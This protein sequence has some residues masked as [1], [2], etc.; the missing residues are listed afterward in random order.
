MSKKG[1]YKDNIILVGLIF[2]IFVILG[3]FLNKF[4]FTYISNLSFQIEDILNYYN[5]DI[6]V[7]DAVAANLKE[8]IRYL[9][10]IAVLTLS[11]IGF[12]AALIVFLIRALSIGYTINTCI[13]VLKLK[14]IKIC[15]LVFMK[16]LII[17]PTAFILFTLSI[18][19]IKNIYK[20]LKKGKQESILFLGKKYLYKAS[21]VIILGIVLQLFL[22]IIII[23]ILKFLL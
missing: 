5:A 20:Q 9:V 17:I 12:I 16:N 18:Q 10:L 15:F 23:S 19:Y 2:L 8:D 1:I 21:I 11:F 4:N 3:A 6:N 14:S 22:N 7:L 13:L